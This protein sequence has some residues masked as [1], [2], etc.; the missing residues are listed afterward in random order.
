MCAQT[1]FLCSLLCTFCTYSFASIVYPCK[2]IGIHVRTYQS[3]V[4]ANN[5]VTQ[6][7]CSSVIVTVLRHDMYPSIFLEYDVT[8]VLTRALSERD[9][10]PP[11]GLSV[12]TAVRRYSPFVSRS[13]VAFS[14]IVMTPCNG[15]VLIWRYR[16]TS[17][18]QCFCNFL[19]NVAL[20]A[21]GLYLYSTQ[22]LQSS[23]FGIC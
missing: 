5:N 11:T 3:A 6:S 15:T 18:M 4:A 14:E 22:F 7:A 19:L 23:V 13:S 17:Y 20:A 9:T 2:I 21:F 1:S 8:S 16:Y 12:A 10:S